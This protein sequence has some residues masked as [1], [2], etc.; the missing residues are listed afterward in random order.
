MGWFSKLMGGGGETGKTIVQQKLP[1]EISPY[2]KDVLKDTKTLYQQRMGEG[3]DPYTGQRIAGLTPQQQQAM[4][5]I[6]GLVG[7]QAPMMQEAITGMRGGQEQF[8]PEAAQQYM[9]P[10]QQAVIDVEKRKAQED[11]ER[12]LMPQ[13][14]KQAVE[15]GGMSGMG[16]RAGVQAAIMG[17]QQAQRLGDIQT[18][19]LQ[20]AYADARRGFEQQK[21]RER[22][23]ATDIA[24]MAPELY[25]AQVK[26]LSGLQQVGEAKQ[27]LTQQGLDKS[28]ADWL[29]A[30]QFPEEQLARYQSSIYGNPL[31]KQMDR[32]TTTSVPGMG[33]GKSL[34][35]LGMYGLMKG[36]FGNPMGMLKKAGGYIGGLSSLPVVRRATNGS[37]S[38]PVDFM[39]LLEKAGRTAAYGDLLTPRQELLD[40]QEREQDRIRKLLQ[41]YKPQFSPGAFLSAFSKPGAGLVQALGAEG[42]ATEKKQAEFDKASLA[43]ELG[44]AKER[45]DIR[46]NTQLKNRLQRLYKKK[47]AL[48]K[49]GLDIRA[50][51]AQIKKTEA[52]A[53]GGKIK[54]LT[55]TTESRMNQL[56]GQSYGMWP[57]KREGSNYLVNSLHDIFKLKANA[58]GSPVPGLPLDVA[59]ELQKNLKKIIGK[60]KDSGAAKTY[61]KDHIEGKTPLGRQV[62]ASIMGRAEALLRTGR[63]DTNT[64]L[65]LAARDVLGKV[66][67]D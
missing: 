36:G 64:A 59:N 9:S 15:A 50:V 2:V 40:T 63:L 27:G 12:R 1:E 45:K 60:D 18:K 43:S 19:G 25:G 51:Q 8:T 21:Q 22:L 35:G 34:A 53:L 66:K 42:M 16:S 4:T 20:S 48:E 54:P 61:L 67:V 57:N 23:A 24:K 14:E 30:R 28:Y 10:Y 26:E 7:T 5:G 11:F 65:I 52:E 55:K 29:E 32:T 17:G 44:S 58:K 47:A 33:L 62:R 39:G 3:Y 49:A 56:M 41:D 6:E 31:L 46:K 13:F 38:P 37:V